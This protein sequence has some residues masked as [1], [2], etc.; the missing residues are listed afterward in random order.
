MGA[1]SHFT[2]HIF[3]WPYLPSVAAACIRKLS[4]WQKKD[5]ALH[6]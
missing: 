3:E 4:N 5:S 6:S 2:G 1:L